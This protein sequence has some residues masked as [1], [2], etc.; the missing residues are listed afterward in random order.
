MV[1]LGARFARP[2]AENPAIINMVVTAR[3][4]ARPSVSKSMPRE[5]PQ[6]KEVSIDR[7]EY[8]RSQAGCDQRPSL[9]LTQRRAPAHTTMRRAIG[10][11]R[12]KSLCPLQATE[13][14]TT[15][16]AQYAQKA[17]TPAFLRSVQIRVRSAASSSPSETTGA[18]LE[19][20][21]TLQ[22]HRQ[23]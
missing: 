11:A 14:K 12:G 18:P 17:C 20:M 23:V 2:P 21:I 4:V 16:A 15:T 6:I 3:D 1:L 13:Q 19:G 10:I 5:Q 22:V 7:A 9:S 8:A